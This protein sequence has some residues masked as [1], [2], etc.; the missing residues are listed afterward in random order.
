MAK[1]IEWTGQHVA[2]MKKQLQ[3][4]GC[5]VNKPSNNMLK[6]KSRTSQI[7]LQLDFLA[8]YP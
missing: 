1:S 4:R 8:R 6:M 2:L 7:I 5:T 3:R